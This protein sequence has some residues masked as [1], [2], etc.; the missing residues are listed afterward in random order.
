[1]DKTH[2]N[3]EVHWDQDLVVAVMLQTVA[4]A[5]LLQQ[6]EDQD[7]LVDMVDMVVLEVEAVVAVVAEAK[8]VLAV[9]LV[10]LMVWVL[11]VQQD[12]LDNP[13]VK[14]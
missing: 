4:V 9:V 2:H 3:L 6:E 7:L 14:V 10:D 11:L 12:S 8:V 1:M 5:L 13:V